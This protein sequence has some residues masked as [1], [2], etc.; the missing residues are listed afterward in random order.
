MR[1]HVQ[2]LQF[3]RATHCSIQFP[4][5]FKDAVTTAGLRDRRII[6]GIMPVA[7][8]RPFEHWCRGFESH[9]SHGCLC[10]F[11]LS[12]SCPAYVA[13]LRPAEPPSKESY[14]LCTGLYGHSD[15]LLICLPK[16]IV[17]N[18]NLFLNAALYK[19]QQKFQYTPTAF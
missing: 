12:L 8:L 6:N 1:R 14:R 9:S 17:R 10:T 16:S 19:G 7:C 18:I 11:I 3:Y 13:P 15:R 2:Q 5:I 4:N